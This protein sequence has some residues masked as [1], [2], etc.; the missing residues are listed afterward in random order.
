MNGELA[1]VLSCFDSSN[2]V[3]DYL[4]KLSTTSTVMMGHETNLSSSSS[5]STTITDEDINI[6]KRNFI[7]PK[8]LAMKVATSVKALDD[9][10]LQQELNKFRTISTTT[11]DKNN[12]NMKTEEEGAGDNVGNTMQSSTMVWSNSLSQ[13]IEDLG[14]EEDQI[15]DDLKT[16]QSQMRSQLQEATLEQHTMIKDIIKFQNNSKQTL[17]SI[18]EMKEKLNKLKLLYPDIAL[19]QEKEENENNNLVQ[20]K[21]SGIQGQN[22]SSNSSSSSSS[23]SNGGSGGQQE[24][25]EEEE[26]DDEEEE[27]N[28]FT[29]TTT[30]NT[31]SGLS[32][33]SPSILGS[34]SSSSSSSSSWNTAFSAAEVLGSVVNAFRGTIGVGSNV[35][36][37]MRSN[38]DHQMG[39]QSG[40]NG[41]ISTDVAFNRHHSDA[42][43]VDDDVMNSSVVDPSEGRPKTTITLP[44]PTSN[45]TTTAAAAAAASTTTTTTKSSVRVSGRNTRRASQ[46]STEKVQTIEKVTEKVEPIEKV[47]TNKRATKRKS[48]SVNTTTTEVTA[49]TSTSTS[50]SSN[51][52]TDSG[53]VGSGNLQ[54]KNEKPTGRGRASAK[55]RRGN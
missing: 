15:I 38:E 51:S 37:S 33:S 39:D 11:H 23:S 3:D 17:S 16:E 9:N 26:I 36:D 19:E 27:E 10:V 49:S 46:S 5:F 21:G 41:T 18:L 42:R 25:E 50:T 28:E 7:Q 52:A 53:T 12:K 24:E 54:A 31:S 48:N 6:V 55:G 40:S 30:N 32:V 45:N 47:V 14:P 4:D 22:G 2:S 8:G 1:S 43:Q 29:T 34:S 20:N 35:N 44:L 13:V